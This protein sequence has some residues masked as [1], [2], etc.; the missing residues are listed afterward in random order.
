MST[1]SNP[2]YSYVGGAAL[3]GIT[4]LAAIYNDRAVFDPVRE[5]ITTQPGWPLVGN[6]PILAQNKEQMHNFL[7]DSFTSLGEL[8]LYVLFLSTF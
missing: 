5:G 8:T 6:L 1:T 4:T 7:L 2:I 3:A